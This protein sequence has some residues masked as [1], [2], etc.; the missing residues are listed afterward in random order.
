MKNHLLTQALNVSVE[1]IAGVDSVIDELAANQMADET[2]PESQSID[3]IN[4][5][6]S[7]IEVLNQVEETIA[8]GNAS[9]EQLAHARGIVDAIG[10]RYGAESTGISMES[11]GSERTS[12]ESILMDIESYRSGLNNHVTAS[13][14]GFFL[15]ASSLKMI[16][17]NLSVM[18]KTIG[19]LKSNDVEKIK[20]I[21]LA[22][23]KTFLRVGGG[24]P[25]DVP[26]AIREVGHGLELTLKHSE[27]VLAKA[28]KA[29][30]IAIA[31]DWT[32]QSAAEKARG[33]IRNLKLNLD[34]ISKDINGYPMFGNRSFGIKIKGTAGELGEWDKSYSFGDGVANAGFLRTALLTIGVIGLLTVN[35]VAG[36]IVVIVA[37]TGTGGKR[38]LPMKELAAALETYSKSAE[39]I[40]GARANAVKKNTVHTKLMSDLKNVNALPKDIRKAIARASSFGWSMSNGVYDVVAHSVYAI[41]NVSVRAAYQ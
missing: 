10:L 17:E 35:V 9:M 7:D 41:A 36:A 28:A 24:A 4:A 25:Q 26:R 27:D 14:E 3:E 2:I 40:Y 8:G 20:E 29:G 16:G 39:K 30:E 15:G 11:V 33:Q 34:G 13:M 32:D 31:T 23:L 21:K 12:M 19:V 22:G 37:T 38:E 5:V 18:K 1:N 6:E